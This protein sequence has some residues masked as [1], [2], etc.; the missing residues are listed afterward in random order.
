MLKTAILNYQTSLKNSIKSSS[1]TAWLIGSI[2]IPVILFFVIRIWENQIAA[3]VMSFFPPSKLQG[4][5]FYRDIVYLVRTEILWMGLFFVLTLVI[6]SYTTR[7]SL[8]NFFLVRSR[9]KGLYYMMLIASV[10]FL[11]AVVI[12]ERVL[13]EFPNSSDEYAYLFQADTLLAI[14]ANDIL[15]DTC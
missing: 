8:E 11:A 14:T 13:E 1:T 10:F 5:A 12:N 4:L 7:H 6:F 9:R 15:K 2:L 3:L